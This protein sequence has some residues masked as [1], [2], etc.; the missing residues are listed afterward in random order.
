M[1]IVLRNLKLIDLFSMEYM[2]GN[3]NKKTAAIIVK[4]AKVIHS[5]LEIYI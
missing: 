5:K 1:Y 4:F 3:L 2:L